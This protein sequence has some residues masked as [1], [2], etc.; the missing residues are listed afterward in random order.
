MRIRYNPAVAIIYLVLG[1][2]VF[3]LGVWLMML[4]D[5]FQFG[6]I[7][8]PFIGLLGVLM[9]TRPYVEL[10]RRGLSRLALLGPARRNTD[11]AEG[12]RFV[13]EGRKM[14]VVGPDGSRRSARVAGWMAHSGDWEA[15]A[16]SLAAG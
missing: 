4:T 1:V 8:G 16:R 9:L 13:I 11:L 6:V 2:L 14:Y 15:A 5:D 12:E 10:S 3:L 7:I